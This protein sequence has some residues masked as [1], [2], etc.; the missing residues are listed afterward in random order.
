M[1]R[2]TE[3]PP[4]Y[5][6]NNFL[7]Q[8]FCH[9]TLPLSCS[10]SLPTSFSLSL[11]LSLSLSF[12]LLS[13]F[14]ILCSSP[15]VSEFLSPLFLFL[16]LPQDIFLFSHINFVFSLSLSPL[17]SPLLP[18]DKLIDHDSAQNILDWCL[19][20]MCILH[21]HTHVP[22]SNYILHVLAWKVPRKKWLIKVNQQSDAHHFCQ[23]QPKF[24]KK[25]EQ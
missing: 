10:S 25:Y 8:S 12:P 1:V 17:S 5:F 24:F 18:H 13:Q 7:Y 19:L 23:P 3:S 22:K 11:S 21:V 16:S 15:S 2:G 20:K 14:F 4:S 9:L 6:L